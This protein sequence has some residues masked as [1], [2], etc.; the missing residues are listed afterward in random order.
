MTARPLPTSWAVKL[1]LLPC[2]IGL[3]SVYLALNSSVVMACRMG[4]EKRPVSG[5]ELV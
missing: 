5:C 4:V 1:R 2:A 3:R